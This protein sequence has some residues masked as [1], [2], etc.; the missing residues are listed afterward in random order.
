MLANNFKVPTYLDP[1][2]SLFI[3]NIELFSTSSSSIPHFSSP[4][5]QEPR[6]LDASSA[7]G[8]IRTIS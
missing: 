7:C 3:V 2:H 1:K 6:Y 8:L 4:F 5:E